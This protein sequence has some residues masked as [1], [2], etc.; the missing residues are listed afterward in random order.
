MDFTLS[1]YSSLLQLLISKEYSFVPFEDFIL[2]G[3][4][5]DNNS[6]I[7]LR[8]D[9]DKLPNNSQNIAELE[10][11]LGIRG[12]YF[13][14]VVSCSFNTDIIKK[15][16]CWDHEI[17]YHY[18]DMDLVRKRIKGKIKNISEDEMIDLAYESF[19][20]NLSK[21]RELAEIKTICMHGS[22]LSKF[23]NK[24]IWKKYNYKNLGIIGEPY[25]DIDWHEWGYLTDTG[26]RWNG[27]KVNIRD[28]VNSVYKLDYKSTYDIIGH[29]ENIPDKIMI[30]VHPQRWNN[31]ILLWLKELIIQSAKN[32][33][34][35]YFFQN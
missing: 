4:T 32:I 17:G 5:S 31:N 26:R 13:F 21:M 22:P 20:E 34:K 29:I 7:I 24:A 11:S 30:T 6:F 18:E 27:N 15:I 1:A 3:L 8:H 28:K 35:K 16:Q 33:I 12:S 25:L 9:V 2:S 23:D 19:C 10:Y 14:R